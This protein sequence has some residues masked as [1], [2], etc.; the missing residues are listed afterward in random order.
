M[1]W[2]RLF[3]P[4]GIA[5]VGASTKEGLQIN[6]FFPSLVEAKF[7][8]KLYPVN[9]HA[10]EVLGYTAYPSV[11][12]IPGPVDYVTVSVPR[13]YI[14]DVVKDCIRKDVAAVH[15]FTAGF[16]ETATEDGRKLSRELKNLIDGRIR[17]IGPN[18]VG[19]Y[20]PAAH[21]GY[22]TRQ[23][24]QPG[25]VG[26]VSQSGGHNS[27]FVEAATSRGLYFSKAISVGNSLDLGVN[28]FLEYLGDDPETRYIGTY[29]EGM[30][31]GKGRRFYELV[32]KI[33]PQKPVMVMK[34]GRGE[35]GARTA[36]GH[37]G[38]MAGTYNLWEKSAE[39][40]N[41]VMVDNYTEM[42]DFIWAHKCLEP[43]TGLQAGVVCGGGGNSVWC[44]DTLSQM[45]LEMPP[46]DPAT[47]KQLLQLTDAVGTIVQNPIDPNFSMMDP[48]VHCRVFETLDSLPYVDFLINVGVFDFAYYMIVSPGLLSEEDFIQANVD[49]LVEIK[50]RTSK[51]FVTA[52]FHISENAEMTRIVD[53]IRKGA[54]ENGVPCYSTMERMAAAVRRVYTYQRRR[55]GDGAIA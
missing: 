37:T 50:K 22:M 47:Q 10:D 40:A 15:I 14:I 3:R 36:A 13:E 29:V 23:S 21:M 53:Q 42:V 27:L 9:R 1:N 8:G 30:T 17:I 45:G 38:S 18:C 7:P 26:F 24:M 46:L 16:G 31:E 54:R 6:N 49:R 12:D 4:R 20:C 34:A 55:N 11:A 2:Q 48:E 51:P 44:S 43:L 39:Q 32:K 5:V 19:V 25:D 28:D 52:A 33:S 41:A 35:A